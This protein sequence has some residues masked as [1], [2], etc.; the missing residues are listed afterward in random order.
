M[1]YRIVCIDCLFCRDLTEN[2]VTTD[3]YSKDCP[4][5]GGLMNLEKWEGNLGDNF[6]VIPQVSLDKTFELK[7]HYDFMKTKF[8]ITD[9]VLFDWKCDIYRLGDKIL[10][11]KLTKKECV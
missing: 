1:N 5:C 9:L 7:E 3:N 2:D 6:P 8:K 10:F 11:E 4:I